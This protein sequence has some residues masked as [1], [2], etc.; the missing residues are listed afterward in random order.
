M[1]IELETPKE[2]I[3]SEDLNIICKE[4]MEGNRKT[5][6]YLKKLWD[7]ESW[8][9]IKEKLNTEGSVWYVW[10]IDG[11]RQHLINLNQGGD[12]Q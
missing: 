7:N 11:V 1:I 8:K 12:T 4:A 10:W 9:S 2:L 6:N 5:Q 3:A